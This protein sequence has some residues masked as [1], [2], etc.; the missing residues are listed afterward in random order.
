MDH[1]YHH[2]IRPGDHYG[3]FVYL[4]NTTYDD[5]VNANPNVNP[6]D[7]RVGQ[8]IIIPAKNTSQQTRQDCISQA[9]VD[10]KND[11]RS[12][13]EEHVAW[14]RMAIISLT[15]KLPDVEFVLARVCVKLFSVPFS[16][17]YFWHSIFVR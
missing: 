11:M 13:W 1:I 8:S 9:A 10:Y 17:Q 4:Y 3:R 15:F 6:H 16:Y 5:I 14:T 2:I 7:L 12:L